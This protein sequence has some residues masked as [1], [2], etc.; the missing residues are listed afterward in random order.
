MPKI[1]PDLGFT[2]LIL[3]ASDPAPGSRQA[4][5]FPTV[6][7]AAPDSAMTLVFVA[8]AYP[9]ALNQVAPPKPL[10][11]EIQTDTEVWQKI[12]LTNAQTGPRPLAISGG[13][14][15][16][17]FGPLGA[18]GVFKIHFTEDNLRFDG[19]LWAIRFTN[20]DQ[21]VDATN[22]VGVTFVVADNDSR[23]PW[24]A[25]PGQSNLSTA[26]PAT[27]DLGAALV[28]LGMS[29]V[30]EIPGANFRVVKRLVADRTYSVS[31]P[32]ANYGPGPLAI[33]AIDPVAAQ[34]FTLSGPTPSTIAPGCSSR[35]TATFA[36]PSTGQVASDATRVVFSLACDDP[37]A[38][39]AG[40]NAHFNTVSLN[41][42][43]SD[44][45]FLYLTFRQQ[46]TVFDL[47]SGASALDV[48]LGETLVA[49]S[50]ITPD[51]KTVYLSG[52]GL[53][54]FDTASRRIVADLPI[55]DLSSPGNAMLAPDPNGQWL[56]ALAKG[57][58][59]VIDTTSHAIA[60]VIDSLPS[61][62][63][64]GIESGIAISADGQL[65]YAPISLPT[66]S[67]GGPGR[68]G[69][70]VFDVQTG[71]VV[72]KTTNAAEIDNQLTNRIRITPDGTR[73]CLIGHFGGAGGVFVDTR[74]NRMTARIP[75][76]S[77]IIDIA[78]SPDG[79]FGYFIGSGGQSSGLNKLD[80]ASNQVVASFQ[81]A[82]SPWGISMHP[83]GRFCYV[84]CASDNTVHEFSIANN[85]FA[86]TFSNI[87]ATFGVISSG[88]FA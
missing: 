61:V 35:L 71:G 47:V 37:Q 58:I 51:L 69:F 10:G 38:A 13:T 3:T 29:G 36:A 20:F 59:F 65:V 82:S 34:H 2:P 79:K 26:G 22:A 81:L 68:S 41:A 18:A 62:E 39:A 5:A 84:L 55:G 12:E 87:T 1:Y 9:D 75:T 23:L 21:D 30:V 80:L 27:I 76:T 88:V 52:T 49:E 86:R 56:Y 46:L 43:A 64:G 40:P 32:V 66:A 11:V 45:R 85:A 42:T 60:R 17:T 53:Q 31:I 74:T 16:Y 67:P 19:R 73:I 14:V 15:N 77:N 83:A 24:I 50:A 78:F 6:E 28:G 48:S 57:K 54:A 70:C 8:F 7:S 44:Y 33:S 72:F 63:A 25:T 4:Q